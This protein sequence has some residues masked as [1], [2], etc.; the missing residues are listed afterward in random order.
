MS[1]MSAAMHVYL[2]TVSFVWKL[3]QLSKIVVG[4]AKM[5]IRHT[6]RLFLRSRRA[7]EAEC[8]DIMISVET[9]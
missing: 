1:S 7:V 3:P 8:G 5:N 4:A 2:L 6:G 9:S